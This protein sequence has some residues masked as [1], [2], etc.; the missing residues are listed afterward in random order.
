MKQ[1]THFRLAL[2]VAFLFF[3]SSLAQAADQVVTTNANSGAGSLSQAITDVT[4]GGSI[5]FNLSAGNETI[6]IAS[7]IAI[8]KAMTINGDNTSGSGVAVTVKV[9]TPGTSA[10]RLLTITA[11]GSTINIQ[12]MTM[13][14]GNTGGDYGGVIRINSGATVNLSSITM[15]NGKSN[16]GGGVFLTGATTN[17][18]VTNSTLSNNSTTSMHGG[19]VY[20]EGSYVEYGSMR[21]GDIQCH[22][23]S[24]FGYQLL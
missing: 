23:W 15:S 21:G 16:Y 11:S 2:I 17:L 22:R 12:N 20:N 7:G 19:W 13:L 24:T 9:T 5:T 14:G 8:T 10:W 4:D 6:T 18:I 3:F 1:F